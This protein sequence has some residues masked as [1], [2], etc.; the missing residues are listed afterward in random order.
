[1][2][3]RLIHWPGVLR[4]LAFVAAAIALVAA[5]ALLPHYTRPYQ[6]SVRL[7]AP[8]TPSSALMR[9]LVRCQILGVHANDDSECLVAWSENR[10][11][12][13]NGADSN[14]DAPNA[15]S[16]DKMRRSSQP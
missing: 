9:E 6:S 5:A 13:F 15:R 1:M 12:F 16:D 7:A 2:R 11:H 8:F 4:F 14:H 10:R 3:G